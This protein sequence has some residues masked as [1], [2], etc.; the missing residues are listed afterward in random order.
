MANLNAKMRQEHPCFS[1]A[2]RE[3]FDLSNA[4]N[5]CGSA[6]GNSKENPITFLRVFEARLK[7][8]REDESQTVYISMELADAIDAT[9]GGIYKSEVKV[10][11]KNN[12]VAFTTPVRDD[13]Q[14]FVLP[15]TRD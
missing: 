14:T 4:P 8:N 2:G 6:G 10:D 3:H 9:S 15:R 5:S 1:L 13:K 12:F 7:K 11:S